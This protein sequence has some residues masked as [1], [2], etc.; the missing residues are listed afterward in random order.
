MAAPRVAPK[1]DAAWVA[2]AVVPLASVALAILGLARYD[3]IPGA[4]GEA[5]ATWPAS[6]SL[7]RTDRPS[8]AVFVHPM[9]PCSR[10]TLAQLSTLAS[11]F[12]DRADLW[13]VLMDGAGA[14]EWDDGATRR[15][16]EAIAGAHLS[17]DEGGHEAARFGART[18][19]H[20]V[21]YS[22]G[23]RL[24]FSGGITRARG[25]LGDNQGARTIAS[26]LRSLP[27]ASVPIAAPVYG[28]SLLDPRP[29]GSR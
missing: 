28:C 25:E 5:P 16:I 22:P 11:S 9:C 2:L 23:G 14:D 10:A 15:S 7:P 20:A 6:S 18:S 4:A 27:V 17:T 1:R 21:L 8:L 26:L 3:S 24:L 29:R 13:V 12:P 19:G